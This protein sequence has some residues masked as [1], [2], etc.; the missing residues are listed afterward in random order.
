MRAAAKKSSGPECST[1]PVAAILASWPVAVQSPVAEEDSTAV[2][3]TE[4]KTLIL[5]GRFDTVLLSARLSFSLSRRLSRLRGRPPQK[6]RPVISTANRRW[7]T[8]V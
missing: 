8:S 2:P 1:K 7:P 5:H 3:K 6:T 4:D